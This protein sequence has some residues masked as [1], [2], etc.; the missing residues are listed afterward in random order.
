VALAKL[1][2]L[3]KLDVGREEARMPV[4]TFVQANRAATSMDI[5]DELTLRLTA[6]G[7]Q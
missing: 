3:R 1:L 2:A 6:V 7:H 4:W 5:S